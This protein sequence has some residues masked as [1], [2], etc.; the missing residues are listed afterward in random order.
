MA[1][2][3]KEKAERLLGEIES[4][5]QSLGTRSEIA[6]KRLVDLQ[7]MRTSVLHDFP[8]DMGGQKDGSWGDMN[9]QTSTQLLR[10]LED[11]KGLYY[12]LD[13]PGP[14]DP[15]NLMFYEYA[16]KRQIYWLFA[17]GVLFTLALLTILRLGWGQAVAPGAGAATILQVVIVAGGLGGCLRL[18]PSLVTYVGNRELL[19]SWLLHYYVMPVLGAGLAPLIYFLFFSGQIGA[20]DGSD[21][22][23]Q[24]LHY[25]V[26]LTALT[27]LFAKDG[28]DKLKDVYRTVF[29]S[30]AQGKDK[31]TES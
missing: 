23:V 15:D 24:N 28:M 27:G 11:L 8:K 1:D 29:A 3:G 4:L 20:Q 25:A 16:T 7:A 5:A 18:L 9:E 21:D 2:T 31:L 13:H 30:T 6:A 22:A 26:A 17:Y 10:R 12:R 14:S 19:R